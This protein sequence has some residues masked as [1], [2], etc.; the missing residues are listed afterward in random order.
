[1]AVPRQ[2]KPRTKYLG[3]IAAIRLKAIRVER[4]DKNT[5]QWID[6]WDD[7]CAAIRQAGHLAHVG[8]RVVFEGLAALYQDGKEHMGEGDG[9]ITYSEIKALQT[10]MYRTM[11]RAAKSHERSLTTGHVAMLAQDLYAKEFSDGGGKKKLSDIIHGKRGFP[12]VNRLGLP[13]RPADWWMTTEK[14]TLGRGKNAKD[15]ECPVINITSLFAH[16]GRIRVI[17]APPRRRGS[18]SIWTVVRQVALIPK[19]GKTISDDGY[20]RCTV[21]LKR[22]KKPQ[23]ARPTWYAIVAYGAPKMDAP[24]GESILYAHRGV[25]NLLKIA[26]ATP[27]EVRFPCPDVGDEIVNHKAQHRAR[28]Q[29]YRR[30]RKKRLRLNEL[31]DSEKNFT[32]TRMWKAA[33]YL[34]TLAVDNTVSRVVMEDLNTFRADAKDQWGEHL[35]AYI[36]DWPYAA[37]KAKIVDTFKRRLGVEVEFVPT[38]YI[39]QRCPACDHV[40]V[41]NIARLPKTNAGDIRR[42]GTFRCV[43]CRYT[44]DL[45]AVALENMMIAHSADDGPDWVGEAVT[46]RIK[47]IAKYK[48]RAKVEILDE[49]ESPPPM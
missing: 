34:R 14:V 28:A 2:K 40:D 5:E 25:A 16:A 43:A 32:D 46:A 38:K 1:M 4:F 9:G 30:S 12:A 48:R 17:C 3:N 11:A 44:N 10:P 35:P 27:D 37:L 23:D 22:I 39:S 21:T 24:K 49:L 42:D 7:Y 41:E 13:V 20:K 8:V 19:G 36:R 31:G 26:I 47:K 6:A 15:V 33:A 29:R 18:D 45:D